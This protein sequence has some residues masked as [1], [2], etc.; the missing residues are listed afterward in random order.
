MIRNACFR[1][2][3]ILQQVV[4]LP[5]DDSSTISDIQSGFQFLN[6]LY[7]LGFILTVF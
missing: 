4:H 3:D 1:H 7:L 2:I 5:H 6:T